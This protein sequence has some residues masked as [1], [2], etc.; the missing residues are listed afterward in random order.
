MEQQDKKS[1]FFCH[2]GLFKNLISN[3]SKINI[4]KIQVWSN[5]KKGISQ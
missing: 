5:S 4:T 3:G 1:N 2:F